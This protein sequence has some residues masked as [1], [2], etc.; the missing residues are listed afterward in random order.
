MKVLKTTNLEFLDEALGAGD[1]D[2]ATHGVLHH[3]AGLV[4]RL[5]AE[6]VLPVVLG[7]LGHLLL[8]DEVEVEL[9]HLV[10]VAVEDDE[11]GGVEGGDAEDAVAGVD[12]EA[13]V[14]ED[15]EA[16]GVGVH[17]VGHTAGVGHGVLLGVGGVEG[18]LVDGEAEDLLGAL[19]ALGES[20]LGRSHDMLAIL[21]ELFDGETGC[22]SLLQEATV[23][24]KEHEQCEKFGWADLML[25]TICCFSKKRTDKSQSKQRRGGLH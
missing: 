18:G 24:E 1:R 23:F 5:P 11:H 22:G 17:L 2:G 20:S 12:E 8:E 15:T 13:P 9:H 10:G 6:E 7:P 25:Y 16:G 14:V 4:P 3:L 19:E 21:D